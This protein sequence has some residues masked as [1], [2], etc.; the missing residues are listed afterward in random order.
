MNQKSLFSSFG[1]AVI[2]VSLLIG[3]LLISFLPSL[4]IDLTEDNLYTLS[5]VSYTHLTLP[6]KA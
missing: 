3:V 5:A 6:T 4:R 1:L 2:A